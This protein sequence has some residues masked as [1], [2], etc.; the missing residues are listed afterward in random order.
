MKRLIV[1]IDGSEEAR[2]AMRLGAEIARRSQATLEIVHVIPDYEGEG[3]IPSMIEF[4][5]LHEAHARRLLDESR[6]AVGLPAEQVQATLLR[7]APA[8]VIARAA[9]SPD[10]GLV[11]I[12]SRGLGAVARTLLGSVSNRLA[13]ISPKPVLVAR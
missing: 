1:A 4:G 12:G 3:E 6:A 11:V 9:E 10:V 2:H 7:G 5:R 8:E 13:H